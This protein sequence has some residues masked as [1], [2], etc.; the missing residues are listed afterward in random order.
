MYCGIVVCTTIVLI[1]I[2]V[3][4]LFNVVWC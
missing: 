2:V 1:S 3:F 4:V